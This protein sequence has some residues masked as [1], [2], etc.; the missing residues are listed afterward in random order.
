M[1]NA[2]VASHLG[3]SSAHHPRSHNGRPFETGGA[4]PPA[5][6]QQGGAKSIQDADGVPAVEKPPLESAATGAA[7][8]PQIYLV[9]IR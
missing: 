6:N 8:L 3:R 7:R 9:K 5:A 1:R 4:R 2:I